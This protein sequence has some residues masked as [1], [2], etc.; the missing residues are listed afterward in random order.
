MKTSLNSWAL[1]LLFIVVQLILTNYLHLSQFVMLTILPAVIMC[2]PAT[3]STTLVMIIAFATGLS[4]DFFA[5]GVIGINTV[6]LLPV[7]ALRNTFVGLVV[8]GDF[9]ERGS[10]FNFKKNGPAQVTMIVLMPLILFLF[11]YI[12]FDGAGMRPFWFNVA[13]FA[14]SLAVDLLLCLMVVKTLNPDDRR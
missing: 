7:A 1:Y 13:R 12:A 9:V 6:A 2:L 10:D 8:G 14:A 4:V 5:E 3:F 11:V